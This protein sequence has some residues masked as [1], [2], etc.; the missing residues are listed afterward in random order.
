[1]N[2]AS[3]I[4]SRYRLVEMVGKGGTGEVWLA[5]DLMLDRRVALKFLTAGLDDGAAVEQLMSEARA[6]AALDHPFICK[7]YEVAELEGR[8]CIVMEYVAGETLE[9]R[10]RRGPVPV[11]ETLRFA[12][13]VAE[14]L[15]AA[16]KRRLVHRDLKPANVML[17]DGDHVKVTDFGLATRLPLR[18]E[19]QTGSEP[20]HT[21]GST[22][23]LEGTPAYMSPEQATGQPVDRRSD[24]FSFGVLLYELVSGIQ[25]FRRMSVGATLT[26]IREDRPTDLRQHLPAAE[27]ALGA[28]VARMMEKDPAER[29]QSFGDVRLELRRLSGELASRTKTDSR[30]FV[31]PS[32]TGDRGTLVGREPEQAELLRTIQAAARGRGGLVV[33]G[34]EA[35]VG[36]SRLVE[37]A[38]AD[39]RQL[40]CLALVGRCYEHAGTPPLVPWIEALEE[41]ARLLPASVFRDVVGRTAPELARLVPEVHRLF[42]DVPPP[43]ELPSELQQRFL[44]NNIQEFL[45]RCSRV[46][47]LAIFLDDLQWADESTL[48]LIHHL[49]PHVVKMA[50]V[51]VGAYRDVDVAAAAERSGVSRGLDH[52]LERVRGQKRAARNRAAPLAQ[53]T[54]DQL[55]EQRLARSV[56]L[57][58]LSE[59]G[60]GS[61]LAILGR[62]EPPAPIT[63]RIFDETGGNP[64]FVE[65]LFRHLK[66]EGRLFDPQGGWRRDLDDDEISVPA[67]V[68]TV[69]ER[70]VRRVDQRTHD[71]LTAAAVVGPHF[72]LDLLEAITGL[73]GDTM[74]AG[75]EQAEQAHLVNGPSGRH[76][77]RWRFAHQ[78]I[79]Q[80]LISTLPQLKRQ[81]LHARIAAAMERIDPGA[82]AYIADI[83]HHLYNAGPMADAG[84]TARAV[85]AAGDAAHAVYATRDAIRHYRRAIDILKE[86]RGLEAGRPSV[87]ERLADL[88]TLT[89]D[90]AGAMA[91]FHELADL[92]EQTRSRVDHA[93]IVRKTGTLHWQSGDRA[94]AIACYQRA[95]QALEAETAHVELALVCQELGLAAFRSGENQEAM[96]WAERALDAAEAAL[97][98]PA[99]VL[100]DVRRM[101]HGAAAHATNTIGIALARSGQLDAA[102]DRIEQSVAIARA[103]GLLDVACRGY[104]NLGVVYGSIEPRRAID[105]SLTGLELATKIG[106]TSLQ[107]YMYANLAAAYCALTERCETEGL[108]A[109]KT[110]A[111]IDRELGQ[112]DHLAVPLIVMAQIHQCQGELQQAQDAYRD[113]LALAEKSGEPQLLF[114]CYDG[115]ATIYLDRGDGA[116]AE[117]YMRRAQ[118]LC[119]RAG[120]DPDALLVLPFLC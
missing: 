120:V 32:G 16:H 1:M 66:E 101:A 25:P 85:V 109:A 12:E 88:L 111:T 112:L 61:L 50:M 67:G 110:A 71:V 87:Q 15:E 20:G 106:A 116:R 93:R 40:G 86:A 90:R 83:A 117:Q 97:A 54:L 84:N 91:H 5:D 80:S 39:A 38:L 79:R 56:R 4:P 26:A 58:P 28:V 72:E 29:Y 60:V 10:L 31:E 13:E 24:I 7:I 81:R 104:A 35:G 33:V 22:R 73:D 82:A 23:M 89:G 70:R 3:V 69:I 42:P 6:A 113:A 21:D 92:Y 114:P 51:V 68:R 103:H 99:V 55:V 100:P 105:A 59:G 34:G 19:R 48:R 107:A 49:A 43:L 62:K 115:L 77:R 2:T 37:D 27:A 30:S 108:A 75:L 76:E 8:P 95:L 44:F 11:A 46:V 47:P 96:R 78:L 63:R 119:E 94:Q 9:R 14:A 118:E 64:F 98:S 57:A 65:E 74:I 45:T 36:K 17:T 18:L 52:L 102:R 53:T 41:A